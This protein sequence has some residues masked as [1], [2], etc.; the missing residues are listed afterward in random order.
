[1]ISDTCIDANGQLV[2]VLPNIAFCLIQ[3][4]FVEW[5]NPSAQG[6]QH[7]QKSYEGVVGMLHL[8]PTNLDVSLIMTPVMALYGTISL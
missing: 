1:M 3:E 4:P 7:I 5:K 2:H 6:V 8:V